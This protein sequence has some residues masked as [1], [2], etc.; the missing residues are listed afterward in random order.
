MSV[1]I[2]DK[3]RAILIAGTGSSV[4]KITVAVGYSAIAG[5]ILYTDKKLH[6]SLPAMKFAG[7]HER[8]L[9]VLRFYPLTEFLHLE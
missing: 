4:G 1:I 3:T 7:H 8:C 9:R 6:K 5:I 2:P